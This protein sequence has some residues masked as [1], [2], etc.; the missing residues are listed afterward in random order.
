MRK[1]KKEKKEKVEKTPHKNPILGCAIMIKNESE[2]ITVSLNSIKGFCDIVVIYDTGSTDGTQEIVRKWCSDNKLSLFMIE[3]KFVDFSISRN[4]M[5]EFGDDKADF[6][7]LLDSNEELKDGHILRKYVNNYNG[8]AI[9]WHLKQ[10][11][12]T[13]VSVDQYYNTKL[14]KTKKQFKYHEPVHEYLISPLAKGNPAM[15]EKLDIFWLFQDRKYDDPKSKPRFLRD[16]E[17]LYKEYK[18]NPT[19]PR[20]MFYLAQTF[21]CLGQNHLSYRFYKKRTEYAEFAEEIY[22]SYYQMGRIAQVLGHDYYEI[23]LLFL[24]AFENT[25]RVEP[26]LRIAEQYVWLGDQNEKKVKEMNIKNSLEYNSN[27]LSVNYVGCSYYDL[28]YNYVKMGLELEYPEKCVLF[29]NRQAYDFERWFLLSKVI[30]KDNAFTMYVNNNRFDRTGFLYKRLIEKYKEGFEAVKLCLSVVDKNP[31]NSNE[32]DIKI[33]VEN[34]KI[35]TSILDGFNKENERIKEIDSKTNKMI[36][37]RIT[38]KLREIKES[39]NKLNVM[40]K[41]EDK[42]NFNSDQ[43]KLSN[44]ILNNQ[45]KFRPD[46]QTLQNNILQINFWLTKYSLPEIDKEN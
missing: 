44:F 2:R 17:L 38:R 9:G 45:E 26:L 12:K 39:L 16:R 14:I 23:F 19:K 27:Q 31:I 37:K 42:V 11:W 33:C 41:E 35:Y 32:N 7:L 36:N 28:A 13:A 10:V 22:H 40:I 34:L 6:L 4:V 20:T 8:I 25:K 15:I 46:E 21:M 29:V 1:N 30:L 24:K 18:E 5:L 3:G 43:E